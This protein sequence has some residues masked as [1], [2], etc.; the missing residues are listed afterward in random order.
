[1]EAPLVVVEEMVKQ[2]RYWV[3]QK[4]VSILWR[5][6]GIVLVQNDFF[7]ANFWLLLLYPYYFVNIKFRK[8]DL[9]I[10]HQLAR[11]TNTPPVHAN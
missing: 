4:K 10:S 5:H 2:P 11:N 6:K 3:Y 1:M 7:R 9:L 8:H